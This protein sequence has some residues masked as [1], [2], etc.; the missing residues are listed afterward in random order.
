MYSEVLVENITAMRE[1]FDRTEGKPPQTI[2]GN[3]DKPL[4]AAVRL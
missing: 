1:I 4:K 2:Q 3:A